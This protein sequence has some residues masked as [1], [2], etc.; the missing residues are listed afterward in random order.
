M[1]KQTAKTIGN[2]TELRNDLLEVYQGLRTGDV[3]TAEAKESSN[4]AG[5]ILSSCKVQME[6][7]KMRGEVPN[8]AFIQ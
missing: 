6:Y 7:T 4:T 1:S 2:V 8:I 5:K 3:S